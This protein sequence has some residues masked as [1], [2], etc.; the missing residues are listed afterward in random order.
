MTRRWVITLLLAGAL[1]A[2]LGG[3]KYAQIQTGIADAR[4]MPEPAETVQAVEVQPRRWA[5]TWQV[6][7]EIR[8]PRALELR[9]EVEGTVVAVGFAAGS[10]VQHRQLLLQLDTREEQAQLRAAEAEAE[11]AQRIL[12]RY[13]TLLDRSATSADQYDQARLQHAIAS[14]RMQALQVRIDRKS[15]RAPFSGQ[16]GL[17]HL[18]V[19]QYLE[20][21]SLVT[22]LTG[23]DDVQWVEF[24][25]PQEAVAQLQTARP[26]IRVLAAAGAEPLPA[27]WLAQDTQI[28]PQ[29]RQLRVRAQLPRENGLQHGQLVQVQLAQPDAREV[30]AVPA[31]AVRQDRDGAYVFVLEAEEG[32]SAGALYRARKRS[33]IPGAGQAQ[34]VAVSGVRAGERIASEG[35][36]KLADGA[37]VKVVPAAALASAER[38]ESAEMAE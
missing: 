37:R 9:N 33:V 24:S 32:P 26:D 13:Q 21:N 35:A 11:L 8:A 15:I 10:H 3:F 31:G 4:S 27:T 36:Y 18:Q 1:L 14:A 25:L 38:A 12:T 28:A 7:G 17:H 22:R 6:S 2:L 23:D 20:A 29:S 16:S 19:G 5:Q 34:W 30:L